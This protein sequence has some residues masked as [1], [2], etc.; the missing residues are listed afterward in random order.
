M[1][2]ETMEI[3][4]VPPKMSRPVSRPPLGPGSLVKT[5]PRVLHSEHDGRVIVLHPE[6]DLCFTLSAVATRL[7]RI[8]SVARR[9]EDLPIHLARDG[10]EPVGFAEISAWLERMVSYGMIDVEPSTDQGS[11][12]LPIGEL[13]K[14][15]RAHQSVRMHRQLTDDQAP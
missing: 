2:L 12:R 7:W 14:V 9:I 15:A 6:G 11:R 5:S 10:A 13:G 8:L 4:P 3:C 1:P